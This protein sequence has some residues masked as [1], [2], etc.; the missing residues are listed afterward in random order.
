MGLVVNQS[1]EDMRFAG[2]L[3]ELNLGKRTTLSICLSWCGI[4][5]KQRGL[6]W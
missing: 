4:G 1:L 3:E 2:I 5:E 6:A